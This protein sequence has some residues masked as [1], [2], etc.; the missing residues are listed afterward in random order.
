MPEFQ[1]QVSRRGQSQEEK[2]QEAQIDAC[3]MGSMCTCNI[4]KLNTERMHQL[5][6]NNSKD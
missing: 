2:G 1:S 6:N 4:L 3:Y 5:K